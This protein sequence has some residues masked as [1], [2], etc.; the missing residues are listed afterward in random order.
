MENKE[1]VPERGCIKILKEDLTAENL[2]EEC[3]IPLLEY[4]RDSI[5]VD[6]YVS[7]Q[8]GDVI[9]S[10]CLCDILDRIQTSVNIYLLG[11]VLSSGMIIAMGGHNNDWVHAYA[12]PST[13]GMMHWGTIGLNEIEVNA[14][15]DY[16]KFSQEYLL[17]LQKQY[18]LDHT[19]MTEDDV[20]N[21]QRQDIW[22]TAQD[23][24]KY[25]IVDEIL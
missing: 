24:L 23:L 22:L 18:V 5:P 12:Y 8:G 13:I 1:T 15:H 7:T 20:K 3:I 4:D 2:H 17:P 21:I 11:E 9:S 10:M 14:A 16:L 6:I 19:E 25:G